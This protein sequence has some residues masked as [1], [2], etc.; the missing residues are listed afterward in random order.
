MPRCAPPLESQWEAEFGLWGAIQPEAL[1]PE[2][3]WN[4]L[5]PHQN[6][7]GAYKTEKGVRPSTEGQG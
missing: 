1:L 2:S 3:H 7:A 4:E 5:E 6:T